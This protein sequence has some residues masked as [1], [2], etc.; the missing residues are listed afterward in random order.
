MPAND[1]A[2]EWDDFATVEDGKHFEPP[3]TAPQGTRDTTLYRLAS[4]LR[5]RGVPHEMAE[6]FLLD[7]NKLHCDPPMEEA[8]VR[9]KLESAWNHPEG[10]S[11]GHGGHVSTNT[12][13]A[14]TSPAVAGTSYKLDLPEEV[15]L[16]EAP[17]LDGPDML[18]AQLS[19]MFSPDDPVVIST[20]VTR[21]ADVTK[22]DGERYTAKEAGE[23]ADEIL[24]LGDPERGM[25]L[26]VNPGTGDRDADVTS[27]RN[28][29]VES[30]PANA[31]EMTD[32]ALRDEL[33][34]QYRSIVA[35]RLPCSC[36]VDSGHKSV[37]AIVRVADD[38]EELT[39]DEWEKRRD[40]VYKVCDANG[41][42]HDPQCQ[43]PSRLCRLAGARRGERTQ[44]LLATGCGA[45]TFS[46]W[47]S[48]VEGQ[49]EPSY[50][51]DLLDFSADT[52]AEPEPLAYVVDD[53]IPRE[54]IAQVVARGGAG[55]TT[56]GYELAVAVAT[57]REWLGHSCKRGR[58][59]YVDPEVHPDLMH[60]R[61]KRVT[62]AMGLRP[63]DVGDR[64]RFISLRGRTATIGALDV[65]LR[66][67]YRHGERFDL[68]ILDSIN[69]LLEGDENSSVDVRA[70]Y[71]Q[72]QRLVRDTH[73]A[74]FAVHHTGKGQRPGGEMG[75]GSSV[76]LDAPDVCIE[77]SPLV[78]EGDSPAG[79]LLKVHS[80]HSEN[81]RL[82]QAT[83]WRM[84][85]PKN[86]AGA[87]I[88]PLDLVFKWPLHIVDNTGELAE[89]KVA[90]SEQGA[91]SKG[92]KVKAQMSEQEAE[93]LDA[94]LSQVIEDIHAE[95]DKATR[96][97]CLEAFNARREEAGMGTWKRRTFENATRRQGRLS[98]RF[99]A[100]TK[101][102]RRATPDEL[103]SEAETPSQS[104]GVP[105][106]C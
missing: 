55:K 27:Y 32:E 16:P 62:R 20:D 68:V 74:L 69:C 34:R 105:P 82:V 9:K 83:A 42:Q 71:A 37:H 70:F 8:V 46:A 100:G 49:T 78:V 65:D 96:T 66:L 52:G 75:R 15:S 99:D 84:T 73:A 43:N 21:H 87:P 59:L 28:V 64:I 33:D 2:L 17:D 85:F 67:R 95:G 86:R 29:L 50:A 89:C 6:S 90:G 26:R 51:F 36:V 41:L 24:C 3:E 31:S 92:G 1:E 7:Y 47:C 11:D 57:G 39:R 94:M 45:E 58:V 80:C 53:L 77:L 102:L 97:K 61:Y 88:K 18:R 101:E 19:A 91:R 13:E 54:H 76:F 12:T 106:E 5:S 98:F 23:L 38:G 10:H 81:G 79:E 103:R 35:L 30:D 14:P 40:L 93:Q 104:G 48:W 60:E 25:W 4:S 44:E 56:L 63:E 72:L 22:H